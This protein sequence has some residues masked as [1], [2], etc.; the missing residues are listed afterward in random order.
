MLVGR[1]LASPTNIRLRHKGLAGTN[2]LAYYE[3][4]TYDRKK[5]YNI[6]PCWSSVFDAG[7]PVHVLR[8]MSLNVFFFVIDAQTEQG[9]LKGEVSLY[10]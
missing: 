1:L 3:N 7:A 9:I 6:G 8:S 4:I 2:A 10:S 5:F